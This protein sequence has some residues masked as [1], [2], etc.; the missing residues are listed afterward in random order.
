M[1]REEKING[2]LKSVDEWMKLE[3]SNKSKGR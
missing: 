2:G 3:K 1:I